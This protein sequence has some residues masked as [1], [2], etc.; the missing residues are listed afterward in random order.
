MYRPIS[1]KV[2]HVA[3]PRIGAFAAALLD[4][5]PSYHALLV[6][7][8]SVT[9]LDARMMS[10]DMP[11]LWLSNDCDWQWQLARFVQSILYMA[12][13]RIRRNPIVVRRWPVLSGHLQVIDRRCY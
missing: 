6:D 4:R 1:R 10:R 8:T 13:S 11:C 9:R 3:T 12:L 5:G 7:R 2:S